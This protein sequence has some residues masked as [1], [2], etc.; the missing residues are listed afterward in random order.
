MRTRR[1]KEVKSLAQD[2]TASERQSLDLL[3]VSKFYVTW[4]DS[5]F[6]LGGL[7]LHIS[8]VCPFFILSKLQCFLVAVLFYQQSSACCWGQIAQVKALTYLNSFL[9]VFSPTW[10]KLSFGASPRRGRSGRRAPSWVF[11][12][13]SKK[14]SSSARMLGLLAGKA[15]RAA[16]GELPGSY[17][18]PEY[19]SWPGTRALSQAPIHPTARTTF[20]LL[21]QWIHMCEL[22]FCQNLTHGQNFCSKHMAGNPQITCSVGTHLN[23]DFKWKQICKE[24]KAG[25]GTEERL[26]SKC[27]TSSVCVS[28][29]VQCMLG[30][31]CWN[32][33]VW[34]QVNCTT[35][36]VLW[37]V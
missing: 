34:P 24:V 12:A 20:W 16:S 10:K 35:T 27:R 31:V 18:Q 37:G 32:M 17:A 33:S 2:H 6:I 25:I 30:H 11:P 36:C 28:K 9:I 1:H 29:R 3:S 26:A 23:Q 7:P 14:N 22:H 13:R 5:P 19:P 4:L 15:Q 8:P 21:L